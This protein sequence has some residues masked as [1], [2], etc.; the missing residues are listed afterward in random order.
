MIPQASTES[1]GRLDRLLT[2][3]QSGKK[4][5]AKSLINYGGFFLAAF[6]LFVVFVVLTTEVHLSSFADIAS[7]GLEFSVL[8]IGSCLLYLCGVDSGTRAGKNTSLYQTT[9]AAYDKLK[10]TVLDRSLQTAV[11]AFCKEYVEREFRDAKTSVLMEA[12]ISYEEYAE[13]Y[14]AK[15]RK[16]VKA[17]SE[18]SEAKKKVIC[19]ANRM[20]PIRLTFEMIFRRGR[21][22]S[23]HAPLGMS[24]EAKRTIDFFGRSLRNLLTTG[25]TVSIALDVVTTPTWATFAKVLL[26][27]LPMVSRGFFGYKFGYENITVD[28]VGYISVQSDFLEEAIR[29]SEKA[30]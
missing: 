29:A 21:G 3:E 20:K 4:K 11:S 15:D 26:Q 13:K 18:L 27:I 9:V 7:L 16:A 30:A 28:T 14:L 19:R 2:F 23:R 1:E 22:T 6:V 25:I 12:G 24:P 17:M 10:R 5:I 8:F